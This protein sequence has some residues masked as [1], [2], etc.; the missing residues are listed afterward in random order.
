METNCEQL[1]RELA[2]THIDTIH[3]RSQRSGF[4]LIA[5]D[6]PVA[7]PLAVCGEWLSMQKLDGNTGWLAD[8]AAELD[9]STTADFIDTLSVALQARGKDGI[10]RAELAVGRA[11]M[12]LIADRATHEMDTALEEGEYVSKALDAQP[13]NYIS[14]F[15]PRRIQGAA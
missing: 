1:L 11:V 15:S 13:A 6:S 8:W 2:E 10:D 3:A 4:D 7:L 12:K 5:R 9:D 14:R